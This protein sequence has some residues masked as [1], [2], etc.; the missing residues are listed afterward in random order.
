MNES[1]DYPLARRARVRAYGRTFSKTV[2]FTKP[3]LL[4]GSSRDVAL[5]S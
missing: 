5:S 3:F 1:S 2:V 4:I